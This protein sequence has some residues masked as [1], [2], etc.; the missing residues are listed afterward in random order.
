MSNLFLKLGRVREETKQNKTKKKKKRKKKEEIKIHILLFDRES[1]RDSANNTTMIDTHH[2]YVHT[3]YIHTEHIH[4]TH[5]YIRTSEIDRD[6]A[7][8][9]LADTTFV[10]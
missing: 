2:A 9:L 10:F 6:I 3:T 4:I 1:I 5:I 8:R 7:I